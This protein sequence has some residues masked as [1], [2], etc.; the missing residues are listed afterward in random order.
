[1]PFVEELA[2]DND[3]LRDRLG[4]SLDA[5]AGTYSSLQALKFELTQE[6]TRRKA[7]E[8]K[9]KEL[10]KQLAQQKRGTV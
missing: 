2:S 7:A 6:K 4:T 10:E 5:F 9:V 1:M 8:A 3:L